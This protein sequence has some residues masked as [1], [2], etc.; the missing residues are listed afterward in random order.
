[1]PT[2]SRSALLVPPVV[3]RRLQRR[4]HGAVRA[5]EDAEHVAAAFSDA[6]IRCEWLETSH[7]F[8]SALL[9]PVLD[10]FESYA[11][12]VEYSPPQLTFVCNR[13][14]EVLTRRSR[15][16]AQY[17]RRH[18]RQPVRFAD[19]VTTLADLGCA[20]LME[21]GPQPILTA[22]AMQTWP[23]TAP[24][25]QTIASLRRDADA[26]RCLTEAL[27]AAYISG[28]R[29]DFAGRCARPNRRS[30]YPPIRSNTAPIGSRPTPLPN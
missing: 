27:A 21:L 9:D 14:G 17:W 3:G 25:P 28:H 22:A 8:H 23:D 10:E 19:S 12:G 24:T 11:G 15:L 18:A 13:T 20:V 7:A 2:R 4:Q 1:M 16:D 30:T 6:G 5:G 29:L 26:P